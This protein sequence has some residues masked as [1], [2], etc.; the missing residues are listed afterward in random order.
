METKLKHKTTPVKE[1][2][3][4]IPS[5]NSRT[6]NGDAKRVTTV[7]HVTG[8]ITPS[9]PSGMRIAKIKNR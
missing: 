3:L 8:Y 5:T 6:A 4:R 2:T 7:R 9:P 1:V